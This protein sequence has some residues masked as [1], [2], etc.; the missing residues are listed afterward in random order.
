MNDID[1]YALILNSNYMSCPFKYLGMSIR[2]NPRTKFWKE[3]LDKIRKNCL[4][5]E[6]GYCLWPVECVF[7]NL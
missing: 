7:S 5:G 4:F 1:N 2:G 6:G 3:M